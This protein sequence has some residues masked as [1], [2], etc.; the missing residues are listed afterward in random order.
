MR[1]A[2]TTQNGAR[3]VPWLVAAFFLTLCVFLGSGRLNSGDACGQLDAAMLVVQTGSFG[4]DIPAGE[5]LQLPTG[6]SPWGP[7]YRPHPLEDFLW[8]RG[9]SGRYFESHD[10][11]ETLFMIGPAALTAGVVE[12]LG[13]QDPDRATQWIKFG[14]ATAHAALAALGCL[15]VYGLFR[16]CYGAKTAFLLSLA[17]VTATVYLP[18]VRCVFDVVGGSV[19]T[20]AALYV[21]GRVLSRDRITPLDAAWLGASCALAVLFRASLV[22]FLG[23]GVAVVFRLVRRQLSWKHGAAAAAAFLLGVLPVLFYNQVR[24]GSPLVPANRAP[25]YDYQTGLGGNLLAGFFGLTV[26]PARGLLFF[27]PIFALLAAVPWIWGA[28]PLVVRQLVM[29]F[30][31]GAIAYILLVSK[32]NIW[33]GS[34]GWGPRYLVAVL[35]ILF[36]PVAASLV[37]LWGRH[38]WA[39]AALVG[40]SVAVNVAPALVNDGLVVLAYPQGNRHDSKLPYQQIA[41]WSA[42]WH[43]LRGQSLPIDDDF[44]FDGMHASE[45]REEAAR[46]PNLWATQAGKLSGHGLW[47]SLPLAAALGIFLALLGTALWAAWAGRASPHPSR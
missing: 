2:E 7:S 42:T 23:M 22:P 31:P 6:Q 15:L 34:T 19:A 5:A 33:W 36:L 38:K 13:C 12:A 43:S 25:Q 8:T 10:L 14:V 32:L 35:P 41:V 44:Y 4:L 40:L 17:Y 21:S 30:F 45:G 37:V 20:A 47:V 46:F 3:R 26:F 18:Y 9:P 39:L 28:M 29:A 24:M 16:T 27:S 1:L 11:G